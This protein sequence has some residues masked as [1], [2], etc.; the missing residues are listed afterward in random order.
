MQETIAKESPRRRMARRV[1]AAGVALATTL[2]LAG[3][4]CKATAADTSVRPAGGKPGV[5][6]GRRQLR[7]QLHLRNDGQGQA[8]ISRSRSTYRDTGTSCSPD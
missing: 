8:C 2:V 1:G 5:F 4:P 6:N 3:L 7:L